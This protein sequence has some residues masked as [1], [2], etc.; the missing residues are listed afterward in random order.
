M[1]RSKN[2]KSSNQKRQIQL[3]EKF[4]LKSPLGQAILGKRVGDEAIVE[5][6]NGKIKCKILKI[7]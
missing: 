5:A 3:R 2:S 4:P 6:P 1:A 7:E